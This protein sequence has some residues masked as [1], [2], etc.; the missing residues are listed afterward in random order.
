MK[1]LLLAVAVLMLAAIPVIIFGQADSKDAPATEKRAPVE[2]IEKINDASIRLLL[3]AKIAAVEVRTAL[4]EQ[5]LQ[6]EEYPLG[7][8]DAVNQ[9]LK[10]VALKYDIPKFRYEPINDRHRNVIGVLRLADDSLGEQVFV[11]EFFYNFPSNNFYI[12]PAKDFKFSM[13]W[14]LYLG[15]DHAKSAVGRLIMKEIDVVTEKCIKG[16]QKV[17]AE[18]SEDP[19]DSGNE[20]VSNFVSSIDKGSYISGISYRRI[21]DKKG[22]QRGV[23]IVRF[24]E[25]VMG[26]TT[27]K[28]TFGSGDRHEQQTELAQYDHE[29]CLAAVAGA[30]KFMREVQKFYKKYDRAPQSTDSVISDNIE[31][32]EKFVE[33][34]D[35]QF[36]V[37][38]NVLDKVSGCVVEI[39]LS[40][41]DRVLRYECDLESD[42][43]LYEWLSSFRTEAEAVAG[44]AKTQ[45][46]GMYAKT[47]VIPRAVDEFVAEIIENCKGGGIVSVEYKSIGDNK[48]RIVVRTATPRDGVL[49]SDFVYDTG[50]ATFV[51][52]TEESEDEDNKD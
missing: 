30:N 22:R 33:F 46:R 27:I 48:G 36:S 25:K 28:F 12:G 31:S 5:Y 45:L 38:R 3:R 35:V 29:D 10:T 26:V 37:I 52:E 19:P 8:D 11:H 40:G 13:S 24:T 34:K 47:G 14:R 9:L 49:T 50:E 21:P 7:K 23:L 6:S 41:F 4:L 39:E 16:I 15:P 18:S 51:W 42:K 2:K 44:S 43:R 17:Y 32:L 20:A 1:N